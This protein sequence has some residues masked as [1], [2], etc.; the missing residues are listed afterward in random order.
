MRI[1]QH[2]RSFELHA[3]L[4]PVELYRATGWGA[5]ARDVLAPAIVSLTGGPELPEVAGANRLLASPE[6]MFGAT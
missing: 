1:P 6:Q 4:S 2:T 3:A 5:A